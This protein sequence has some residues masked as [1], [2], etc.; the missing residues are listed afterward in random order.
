MV[1][2]GVQGLPVQGLFCVKFW[3]DFGWL[4]LVRSLKTERPKTEPMKARSETRC[5]VGHRIL[6]GGQA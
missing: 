2:F 1:R 5:S 4:V 3:V 6:I